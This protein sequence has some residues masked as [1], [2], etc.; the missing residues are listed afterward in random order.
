MPRAK[1]KNLRKAETSWTV[2]PLSD[3]VSAREL[4][5]WRRD[6]T[7]EKILRYL[8]RWRG[9]VKEMMAEGGTV[10]STAEATQA[11][12]VEASAK[13][14]LLKDLLELKPADIARFYGTDEPREAQE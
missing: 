5:A 9:E 11:L 10:A 13:A 12:T 7:T 8:S 2:D 4:A 14:Q 1:T 3:L 6:T